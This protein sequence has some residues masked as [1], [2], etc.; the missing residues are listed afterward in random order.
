MSRHSILHYVSKYYF[1]GRT[2]LLDNYFR[3]HDTFK[4]TECYFYNNPII[5]YI[6]YTARSYLKVVQQCLRSTQE[7]QFHGNLR[8]YVSFMTLPQRTSLA[9]RLFLLFTTHLLMCRIQVTRTPPRLAT[10]SFHI[11]I[12]DNLILHMTLTY[13]KYYCVTIAQKCHMRRI[14]AIVWHVTLCKFVLHW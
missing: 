1:C 12:S 8:L 14:F 13:L 3:H 2:M 4:I 10:V 5:P 7:T 11:W 6:F 9:P